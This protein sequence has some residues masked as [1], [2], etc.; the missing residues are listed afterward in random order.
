[1]ARS[2]CDAVEQHPAADLYAALARF[3]RAFVEIE[4]QAFDLIEWAA[5]RAPR[6][7]CRVSGS[8]RAYGSG[9]GKRTVVVARCTSRRK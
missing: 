8:V 5:R 1:M 3:T 2:L 6:V 9:A 4:T 7:A